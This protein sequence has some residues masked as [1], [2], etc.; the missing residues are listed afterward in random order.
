M[1]GTVEGPNATADDAL[2][3]LTA[4]LLT[5]AQFPGVLGDDHP[6]ACAA[7]GLAPLADGYAPVHG[8][9]P[10]SPPDISVWGPAQHRL[11]AGEI[12]LQW[13]AW[14][15]Q[16]DAAAFLTPA[17]P[18]GAGQNTGTEGGDETCRADRTAG[19]SKRPRPARRR[20]RATAASGGSWRSPCLGG[21]AAAARPGQVFLRPG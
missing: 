16:T 9:P 8:G 20:A 11:G 21:L 19:P 3:V 13:T 15:E 18:A 17:G 4:V 5:P 6:D 2:Y 1:A 14:R 12:A 10:L 7:L